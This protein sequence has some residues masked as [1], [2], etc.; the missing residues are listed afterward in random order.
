MPRRRKF[1]EYETP[2]KIR[3]NE[4]LIVRDSRQCP[5]VLQRFFRFAQ[6]PR[7]DAIRTLLQRRQPALAP[8]H[9]GPSG[10]Q[11]SSPPA[12]LA[13]LPAQSHSRASAEQ[14]NN[15]GDT[16]QHEQ[17]CREDQA[18]VLLQSRRIHGK[19][20]PSVPAPTARRGKLAPRE[21]LADGVG[22]SSADTR[23]PHA[24]TGQA[25]IPLHEWQVQ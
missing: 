22:T 16:D 23:T 2:E 6:P 17:R 1:L 5:R 25:F 4:S 21:S 12:Q 9:S 14:R 24:R 8:L 3:S 20:I 10:F 11:C 19:T 13:G 7:C 18:P 15:D